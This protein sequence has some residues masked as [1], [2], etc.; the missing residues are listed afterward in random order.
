[1][2]ELTYTAERADGSIDISKAP[3]INVEFDLSRQL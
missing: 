3:D 1:V 2:C